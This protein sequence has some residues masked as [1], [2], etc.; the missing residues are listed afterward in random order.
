MPDRFDVRKTRGHSIK[1]KL[2]QFIEMINGFALFKTQ[3]VL[4]SVKRFQIQIVLFF[5][6]FHN[7]AD[8][9]WVIYRDRAMFCTWCVELKNLFDSSSAFVTGGFS[10]FRL[11]SL[12]SRMR[13]LSGDKRA[14]HSFRIAANPQ[15]AAVPRALRQLNKECVSKLEKLF[16]IAYFVEKLEMPFTTYPQLYQL[17]Q[18]H[19]IELGPTYRTDI[20]ACKNFLKAISEEFKG[21]LGVLHFN[22]FCMWI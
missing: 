13:D 1:L 19:G 8:F 7:R 3:G 12:R 17:E 22:T 4:T 6:K 11:E 9:P 18:K 14:E 2:V 16:D 20:R 15:E 5:S 10:N 21:E